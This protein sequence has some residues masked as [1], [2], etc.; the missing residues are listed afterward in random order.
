MVDLLYYTAPLPR[1]RHGGEAR[2]FGSGL[3][4]KL[5]RIHPYSPAS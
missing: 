5:I 4:L 3:M 1:P 2:R